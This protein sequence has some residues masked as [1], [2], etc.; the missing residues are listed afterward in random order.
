MAAERGGERAS[1]SDA[2]LNPLA[3]LTWRGGG[4]NNTNPA[5]REAVDGAA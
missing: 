2:A 1:E 3:E 4:G 5:Y